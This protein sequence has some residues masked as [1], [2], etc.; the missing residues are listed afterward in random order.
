MLPEPITRAK[1][2][3]EVNLMLFRTTDARLV[4][5][6]RNRQARRHK[7]RIRRIRDICVDL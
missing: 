5:E 7:N 6:R 4:T 1:T 3:D 2:L